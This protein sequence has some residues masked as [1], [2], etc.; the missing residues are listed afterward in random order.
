MAS[1]QSTANVDV[2]F[3]A[4]MK[5]FDSWRD[6]MEKIQD[7]TNK[8]LAQTDAR[9]K[10]LNKTVRQQAA[11]NARLQK[12][13][14]RTTQARQRDTAAASAQTAEMNKA[15]K[16]NAKTAQA[17]NQLGF[18]IEDFFSVYGT[19]GAAGGIRAANNNLSMVARILAGPGMVG[20]GVAIGSSLATLV[21][22]A[23]ADWLAGTKEIEAANNRIKQQLENQ[24]AVA[25]IV[26]DKIKAAYAAPT[27]FST[28]EGA[29][30]AKTSIDRQLDSLE[31]QQDVYARNQKQIAALTASSIEG[32]NESRFAIERM[33]DALQGTQMQDVVNRMRQSMQTMMSDLEN[34]DITAE[35]ATK[36]HIK[37]L[38]D[39]QEL[40]I[41]LSERMDPIGG[42]GGEVFND[43]RLQELFDSLGTQ[44]NMEVAESINTLDEARISNRQKIVDLENQITKALKD[45]NNASSGQI[46][47][48]RKEAREASES[49]REMTQDKLM[50]SV[51]KQV[52]RINELAEKATAQGLV[53][54]ADR[55]AAIQRIL[56]ESLGSDASQPKVPSIGSA[57]EGTTIQDAA[58]AAITEAMRDME[59][60]DKDSPEE[61]EL[62]EQ[63][64]VLR[65]VLRE[66]KSGGNVNLAL[67]KIGV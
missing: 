39:V 50:L 58:Q 15:T 18:A 23:I 29:E 7:Q 41:K 51:Q 56:R 65:E 13:L 46:R 34:S 40:A 9:N 33:G 26:A 38:E 35:E 30:K 2:V 10:E 19:M 53:V 31:E 4:H 57:V 32:F 48:L 55:Q 3:E 24:A 62:K 22:P 28:A 66:I 6:R 16:G 61:Q 20:A 1:G 64:K 25:D 37:R 63:T 17:F 27:E 52:E 21:I 67:R 44:L 54:E 8:K 11:E 14:E 45:Q 5:G 42:Y 47:L 60:A 43:Q 12:Q 59:N 49:L 36:R